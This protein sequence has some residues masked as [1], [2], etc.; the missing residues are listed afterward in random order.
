MTFYV[1]TF[2]VA[3]YLLKYK[4]LD[5]QTAVGRGYV[6]GNSAPT[7]TGQTNT[8]GLDW[9]ESTGK[10]KSKCL[11]IEDLWGN[12]HEWFDGIFSNSTRNILT[13]TTNSSMNDTG[14]GYTD[15]GQGATADIGN[16]MNEV[17][18][19]TEKGFVAKSV[20]GSATTYF[21]DYGSLYASKLAYGGGHYGDGDYAGVF[22][23]G[24]DISASNAG[25]NI[26]GR[27]IKFKVAS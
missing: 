14:S 15:Q 2:L 6:D 11:G 7:T 16:Y 8:K 18:G 26:G 10:Y 13:A 17:Q 24:V 9:G 19:T 3:A 1:R 25:A 12:M 27:L 20:S 21:C 4:N 5:S 23:C 22:H